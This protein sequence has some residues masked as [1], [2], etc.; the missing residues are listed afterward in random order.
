M[1]RAT[2]LLD[3][4][5]SLKRAA[6]VA[7]TARVASLLATERHGRILERIAGM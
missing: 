2:R 4:A 6:N 5:H 1:P 3:A 7:M